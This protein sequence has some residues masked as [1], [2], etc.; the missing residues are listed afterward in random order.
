MSQFQEVEAVGSA[1][2]V[3]GKEL[4]EH[5]EVTLLTKIEKSGTI[6]LYHCG[7]IIQLVNWLTRLSAPS[8]DDSIVQWLAQ[9][10]SGFCAHCSH[11]ESRDLMH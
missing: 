7:A 9:L 6:Y 4:G 10:A 11:A 5:R 2:L 1:G 3:G 8:Y